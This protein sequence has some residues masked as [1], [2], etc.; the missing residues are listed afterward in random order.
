MNA[1]ATKVVRIAKDGITTYNMGFNDYLEKIAEE[2]AQLILQE[3][4][5]K[6]KN[7]KADNKTQ[8]KNTKERK[9]EARLKIQLKNLEIEISQLENEEIQLNEEM[10]KPEISSDYEKFMPIMA[11]QEVVQ[12]EIANKFLEWEI[13]NEK[14]L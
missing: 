5:E 9:E 2:N 11:R 10:Q 4:A 8:F 3:K 6:L 7:I 14:I 13:L 1:I 12:E